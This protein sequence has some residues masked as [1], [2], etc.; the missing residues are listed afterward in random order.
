M[1]VNY[2]TP[3]PLVFRVT[4]EYSNHSEDSNDAPSNY[5]QNREYPKPDRPDRIATISMSPVPKYLGPPGGDSLGP[6]RPKMCARLEQSLSGIRPLRGPQT[7]LDDMKKPWYGYLRP[8][9]LLR[10]LDDLDYLTL[11]RARETG[12]LGI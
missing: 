11:L 4:Q 5:P 1:G 2:H 3:G 12:S 8:L 7:I 6:D 10:L 9:R